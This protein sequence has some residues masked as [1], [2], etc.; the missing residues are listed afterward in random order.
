MSKQVEMLANAIAYAYG[1]GEARDIEK[2]E[3]ADM[4][5]YLSR[6]GWR[7]VRDD[8]YVSDGPIQRALGIGE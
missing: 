1:D 3:A 6:E 8:E 2:E 7:L 5:E 4:L